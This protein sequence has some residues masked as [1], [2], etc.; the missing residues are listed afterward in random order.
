MPL[1][2]IGYIGNALNFAYRAGAYSDYPE[3]SWSAL[4]ILCSTHGEKLHDIAHNFD[5]VWNKIVLK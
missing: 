3:N 1:K 5:V 2:L 4:E